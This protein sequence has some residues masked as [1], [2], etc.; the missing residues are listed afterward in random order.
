MKNIVENGG[1]LSYVINLRSLWL[2]SCAMSTCD[3]LQNKKALNKK[4]RAFILEILIVGLGIY[5]PYSCQIKQVEPLVSSITKVDVVL[6]SSVTGL[7]PVF[8]LRE[9]NAHF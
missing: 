3:L 4:N 9:L 7:A 1:S 8:H 6:L 5:L 2:H